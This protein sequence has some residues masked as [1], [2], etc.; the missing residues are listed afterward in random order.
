MLEAAITLFILVSLGATYCMLQLHQLITERHHSASGWDPLK[1]D[2]L[3]TNVRVMRAIWGKSLE[4]FGD[5]QLLQLRGLLRGAAV[6]DALLVLA[7]C[8]LLLNGRA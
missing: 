8:A 3:G 6:A 7:I 1:A 5:P 2:D 4:T